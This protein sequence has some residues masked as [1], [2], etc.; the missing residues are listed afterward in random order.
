MIS[1]KLPTI[2]KTMKIDITALGG[3][4]KIKSYISG[5]KENIS[6][7]LYVCLS[8]EN[9]DFCHNCLISISPLMFFGENLQG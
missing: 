4:Q 7:A 2:N 8:I 1:L 3:P 5:F 6:M 9:H